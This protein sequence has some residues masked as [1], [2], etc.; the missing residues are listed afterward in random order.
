MKCPYCEK[1]G[2]TKDFPF[3]SKE[4]RVERIFTSLRGLFPKDS[5]TQLRANAQS[6]CHG[7]VNTRKCSCGK[8]FQ[9]M[10]SPNRYWR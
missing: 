8:V 3:E 6:Y 10:K 1:E 9:N 7:S 5:E 4:E 2:E